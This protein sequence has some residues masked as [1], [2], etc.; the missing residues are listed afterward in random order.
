MSLSLEGEL[1]ASRGK[2]QAVELVVKDCKVLGGCDPEVRDG[3][4]ILYV[5]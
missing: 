4:L 3:A 2:G 1:K 5:C